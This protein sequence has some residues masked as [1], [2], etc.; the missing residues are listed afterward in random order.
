G[1][2]IYSPQITR[3]CFKCGNRHKYECLKGKGVC[4]FCKQPGHTRNDC[5]KW[6][7][8]GGVESSTKGKGRVYTMGGTYG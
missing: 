7:S 5:P 8:S 4:Y 3:L 2:H 6:K 1:K